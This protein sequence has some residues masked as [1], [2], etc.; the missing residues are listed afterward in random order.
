MSLSIE[1]YRLGREVIMDTG[2][3]SDVH[4]ED[5][6]KLLKENNEDRKLKLIWGWIKQGKVTFK[7]FKYYLE[8]YPNLI[9]SYYCEDHD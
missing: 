1:E 3:P 5:I 6:I 8:N 2:A 7:A 9:W 4:P